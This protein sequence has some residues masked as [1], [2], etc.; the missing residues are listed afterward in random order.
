MKA[1]PARSNTKLRFIFLLKLKSKL[2]SVLCGSRNA[3]CF[4]LRS[5]RRSPRPFSS[6]GT[7]Q[8]GKAMGGRGWEAWVRLAPEAGEFP[9]P[10]PCLLSEVGGEH[11]RARSRS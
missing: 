1:P 6:S 10:Q 11:D 8:E 9:E 2:S 4:F 3:A 5:S 7:R